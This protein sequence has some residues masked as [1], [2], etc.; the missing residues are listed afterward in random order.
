MRAVRLNKN[1]EAA[2]HET[3]EVKHVK[4]LERAKQQEVLH[5]CLTSRDVFCVTY[6]LLL[7]ASA[8]ID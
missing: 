5:W 7:L 3:N 8:E 6:S 1:S 2:G 4:M